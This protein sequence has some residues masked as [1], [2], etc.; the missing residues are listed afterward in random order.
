MQDITIHLGRY[1][2]WILGLICI[3]ELEENM[4]EYLSG[5]PYPHPTVP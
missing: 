5:L 3:L 1:Q 2:F 4:W